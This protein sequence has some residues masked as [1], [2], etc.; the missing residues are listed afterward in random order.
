MS[1]RSD[2][3]GT[4]PEASR[5][6]MPPEYG[7]HAP[8]EGRGVLPWTWASERLAVARG[9]WLATTRPDG[10][11]HV[12]VVW[13]VW[14]LDRYYFATSPA[15]RKGRN[16]AANPRCV[17]C[18]ED[19]AEAVIVE[20][21]AEAVTDHVAIE[22]FSAAYA[23]KYAEELDTG[24]FQVYCVRPL[25]VFA[26]LS[27]AEQFPTTATRWRFPDVADTARDEGAQPSVSKRGDGAAGR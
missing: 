18:P 4:K 14:L 11:P 5:P 8:T 3:E 17:V 2:E 1:A 7:I 15:S 6:A 19:T 10:R 13:G 16:L 27:D 25:V 26:T 24:L 23:T 12:A 20:G 21:I 9:Y 22:R